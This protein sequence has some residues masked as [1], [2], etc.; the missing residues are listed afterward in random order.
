MRARLPKEYQNK[1]AGDMNS[2]IR[3]AQKMQDD[4]KIVQDRLN[5]TEFTE[6][7]GGGMI[8]LTMTGGRVLKSVKINPE[9]IDPESPEDL[10]DLVLAG[11]N[12][13]IEK[14]DTESAAEMEK[15]TGGVNMPGLF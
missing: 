12:A 13:I 1:G 14:V 7:V 8:T 2:M 9:V 11:V 5:E 10:E 4:I 3:Q 15:V 6:T